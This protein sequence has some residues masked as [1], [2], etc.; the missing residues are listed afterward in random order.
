MAYKLV[1]KFPE[2][3][4]DDIVSVINDLTLSG[5]F[6][7]NVRTGNTNTFSLEFSVIEPYSMGLFM[8]AFYESA[9][10]W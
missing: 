10:E 6:G 3:Y 5:Q 9:S 7:F 1:K 4:S 2:N 8:V